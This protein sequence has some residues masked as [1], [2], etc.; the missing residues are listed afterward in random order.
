MF[1]Q[2]SCRQHLHNCPTLRLSREYRYE[3]QSFTV[4]HYEKK[5][6]SNMDALET[7]QPDEGRTMHGNKKKLLL[8]HQIKIPF[9]FGIIYSGHLLINKIW[10]TQ[11]MYRKMSVHKTQRESER[12]RESQSQVSITF[13]APTDPFYSRLSR[14][15]LFLLSAFS[16]PTYDR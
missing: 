11:G 1:S 16:R 8:E 7:S 13:P 12:D 4:P 3:V 10:L 6:A 15:P 2:R 14:F 9:F 5:T